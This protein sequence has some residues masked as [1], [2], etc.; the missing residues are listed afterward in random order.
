A[1]RMLAGSQEGHEH[2]GGAVVRL[3]RSLAEFYRRCLRACLKAPLVVVLVSVLFAGAA[4]AMFGTIRNELTPPEDRS[5]AFLR[6]QAPQGVSLDYLAGQMN[7]IE[8]LIRPLRD[9]GEIRS[10]FSIAGARGA[11]NTGFMVMSLAPWEERQRTQ[12][13]ILDEVSALVENVPGVRAFAFQPNSLGIRGA[14][15]GLQFALAGY[16]YQSLT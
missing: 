6:I 1:S 9:S 3:G 2:R 11:K 8:R 16:S 15:S 7:E 4:F 13:E 10:T 12:Q 14:G 5:M